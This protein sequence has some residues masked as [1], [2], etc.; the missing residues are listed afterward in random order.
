[1]NQQ[2]SS[3]DAGISIKRKFET[4]FLEGTAKEFVLKVHLQSKY[5]IFN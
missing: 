3:S 1:M 4:P 2:I 5:I